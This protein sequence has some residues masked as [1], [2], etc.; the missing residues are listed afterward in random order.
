MA[1]RRLLSTL[2]SVL[3]VVGVA[4]VTA[5][6]DGSAGTQAGYRLVIGKPVATPAIAV[7]GHPLAVSFKVTRSDTGAPVLRGQMMCDP[8]VAGKVIRHTESFRA[9]TARLSF[10]VPAGAAGKVLKVH[11]TIRAGGRSA[12]RVSVFPIAKVASPALAIAAASAAEGNIGMTT[13]SLPVTLSA[14]TSR[15]VSVT[16]ATADGT[17]TAPSDYKAATGVLTFRPGEKLKSI[18]VN[19]V[20]DTAVEQNETFTV[21]LSS[22]GNATI[23]NGSATA[24]ITNDDTAVPVTAGNYRG[25]TVNN[26]YVFFTVLPNRTLT[27]FRV[28]NVSEDCIPPAKLS[29]QIDWTDAVWPILPDASFIAAGTWTGSQTVGDIEWTKSYA[30]VTGLFNGTSVSG[31]LTI[32]DELNY[33]G[34]HFTCSTIDKSWSAKLGG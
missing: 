27:G 1:P 17:A 7:A 8:A 6:A 21:S 12:T 13:L 16:Y 11:L 24:T 31:T 33:Q 19:V 18:Q 15:T 20:G 28:N 25:A 23:A 9:G 22:P 2:L 32:R 26:D 30:K 4:L 14:T 5:T 3:G 29:G 34:R 10:V